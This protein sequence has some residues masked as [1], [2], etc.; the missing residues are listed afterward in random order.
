[1][2]GR[3]F[4]TEDIVM[5]NGQI[6]DQFGKK[7]YYLDNEIHRC[8]GPAVETADGFVEWHIDGTQYTK[9]DFD[10]FTHNLRVSDIGC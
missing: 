4:T 8:D 6:V 2:D 3:Y 7:T 1:M 5:K 10:D 9:A